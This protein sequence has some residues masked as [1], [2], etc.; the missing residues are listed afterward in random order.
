MLE[1]ALV[2]QVLGVGVAQVSAGL[3]EPGD[4][5]TVAY[6]LTIVSFPIRSIGWMLGEFPRSVV[7]YE[8]V[9][10]V[11]DT[12]S[13]TTY[14]AGQLVVTSSGA[15]LDVDDPIERALVGSPIVDQDDPVELG[16]VARSFDSCLVCTV[17]AYDG[18]TGKELSKFVVNGMV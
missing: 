5:V 8:R 7:G 16:H 10:N 9:H 15:A 12:V 17:H 13:D 4:V 14:G 2:E 3:T 1:H 11:L 6:L 18:K